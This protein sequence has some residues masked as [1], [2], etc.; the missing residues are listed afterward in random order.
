LAGRKLEGPKFSAQGV[1]GFL[2]AGHVS[3]IDRQDWQ[4]GRLP[5]ETA[6]AVHLVCPALEFLD[7]GKT[8]LQVPAEMTE[9]I[10]KALWLVA[11]DLYTEEERRRKDAAREAR[12]YEKLEKVV[13]RRRRWTLKD[14]VFEVLPEALDHAT[15]DGRYPASA[16]DLYYAVRPLVRDY[17]DKD[18]DYSYFSQTLLTEYRETRGPIR[19][20]YYD[21][22][23][24]LYEPHT[25]KAIALGTREVDSYDFPAWLYGKILYVEKKGKWPQLEA[26]RLAERFDLAVIAA[27]G[28]ATEA[29]RTLFERADKDRQYR[30]FVLHDADPYGY[31]IAR[32]LSEETRRMPGYQVDVVDLGLTLAEALELGLEMEEF[33]RKKGL[34]EG[35]EL[36]DLERQHFEGRRVGRKSWIC[37]RVELNALTAPA[38]IEYIERK[39]DEAGATDKV[40]PT[41]DVLPELAGEL[42]RKQAQEWVRME[43]DR[44]LSVPEKQREIADRFLESLDLDQTRGWIETAFADD[45]ALS[46]RAAV[47]AKAWELLPRKDLQAELEAMLGGLSRAG[48][49]A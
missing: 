49:G 9:A 41:D 34:P 20:L 5:G 4:W 46:W 21:P 3:P 27:E 18:L 22:R 45:D 13:R 40:I 29:A 12:A 35:L 32:T 31:N 47:E 16:R 17:T 6:A 11:K 39:L 25:G 37:K 43:L 15:G 19:G 30:L 26:A 28:Y 42:C 44:L 23:G 33:T 10:A 36:T 8:R 1:G 14:A 48:P 7:R 2:N 24:V 38:F